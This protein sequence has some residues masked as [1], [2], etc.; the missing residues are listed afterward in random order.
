MT[1]NPNFFDDLLVFLRNEDP[2]IAREK[3]IEDTLERVW[4]IVLSGCKQN[5]WL[6]EA[7][8]KIVVQI[9]VPSGKVAF[10]LFVK[11]PVELL[12][13]E[14]VYRCDS[15]YFCSIVYRDRGARCLYFSTGFHLDHKHDRDQHKNH[16]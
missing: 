4:K 6:V 13:S 16:H 9:C 2:H 14:V 10:E 1:F 7:Y 12:F 5:S 8:R 11:V 3:I 15:C